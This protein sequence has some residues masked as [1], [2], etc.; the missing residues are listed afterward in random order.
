VVRV[1]IFLFFVQEFN[2]VHRGLVLAVMLLIFALPLHA[3]EQPDGEQLLKTWGCRS[4]HRVGNFGGNLADDLSHI[5]QRLNAID[6]RLKL[7]PL[8]GQNKGALMPTYPE[9]SD[10]EVRIVCSYLASLK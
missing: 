7:H 3:A 6:I 9:M 1:E 8:P 10:D 4:C 2:V 5:G